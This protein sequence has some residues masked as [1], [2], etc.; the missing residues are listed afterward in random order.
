MQEHEATWRYFPMAWAEH[1][2]NVLDRM[3]KFTPF[4]WQGIFG[5]YSGITI[6]SA[7]VFFHHAGTAK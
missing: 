3:G 2:M 7:E 5:L 6:S 4:T 1:P